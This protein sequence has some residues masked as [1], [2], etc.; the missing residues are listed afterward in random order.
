MEKDD[1]I[2]IPVQIDIEHR[3]GEYT[4]AVY[5]RDNRDADTG[6]IDEMQKHRFGNDLLGAIIRAQKLQSE[7]EGYPD[8]LSIWI[9]G[10]PDKH[11]DQTTLDD[12]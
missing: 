10:F 2:L 1:I 12:I 6:V 9:N 11:P 3:Q 5:G 7:I 4:V 8:K